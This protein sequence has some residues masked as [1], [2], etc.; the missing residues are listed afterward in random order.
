MIF[1]FI[2]PKKS[3]ILWWLL[4]RRWHSNSNNIIDKYNNTG[5][6]W[7]MSRHSLAN[8]RYTDRVVW[9]KKLFSANLQKQNTN[10]EEYYVC[11][12][13]NNNIVRWKFPFSVLKYRH[14]VCLLMVLRHWTWIRLGT[15]SE[16]HRIFVRRD[17]VYRP[18]WY[19]RLISLFLSSSYRQDSPRI[20][21][22]SNTYSEKQALNA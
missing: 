5:W 7:F 2:S 1:I 17:R 9:G 11:C 22:G 6:D 16:T 14:H 18:S 3:C 12:Y 8:G 19:P 4:L 13:V 21:V 15:P 10:I 20:L